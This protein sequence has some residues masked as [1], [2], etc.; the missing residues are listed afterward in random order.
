MRHVMQFFVSGSG[1]VTKVHQRKGQGERDLRKKHFVGFIHE[2][3]IHLAAASTPTVERDVITTASGS[4]GKLLAGNGGDG[5][6]SHSTITRKWKR[7]FVDGCECKSPIYTAM[8]FLNQCYEVRWGI[9]LKNDDTY[10]SGMNELPS[11][12]RLQFST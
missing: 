12:F 10:L 4:G 7:P 11:M 3:E 9:V 2:V 5:S 8:E 1:N 6:A